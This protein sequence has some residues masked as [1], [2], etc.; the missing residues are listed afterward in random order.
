MEEDNPQYCENQEEQY[1][2][3]KQLLGQG[4]YGMVWERVEKGTSRKVAVK[5][6]SLGSQFELQSKF[7]GYPLP[8]LREI[9]ILKEL[10]HKN[11]V[12]CYEFYFSQST[13]Y[14][15]MEYHPR[16]LKKIIDDPNDPLKKHPDRI[17][18]YL[19]MILEGVNY[20]HENFLL[21]RVCLQ[22]ESSKLML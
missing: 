5:E 15:V 18:R 19:G 13:L 1:E 2:K 9:K 14:M 17:K 7:D 16:D 21:H 20:L 22:S 4:A 3:D 6:F 10:D 11:I 8:I 12:K